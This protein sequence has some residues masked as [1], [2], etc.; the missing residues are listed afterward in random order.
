MMYVSGDFGKKINKKD[1]PSGVATLA[2]T[3]VQKLSLR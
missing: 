3:V 2:E 1:V